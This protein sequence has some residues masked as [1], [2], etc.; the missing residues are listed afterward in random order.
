L[1]DDFSANIRTAT[2][3]PA[4]PLTA[5]LLLDMDIYSTDNIP[6]RDE[7]LFEKIKSIQGK[8]NA[9]FESFITDQSR[10]IFNMEVV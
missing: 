8:K 3:D 5:A 4:I 1:D 6:T 7:E 2:T 10:A 9:L